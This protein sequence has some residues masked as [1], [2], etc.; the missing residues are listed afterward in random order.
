MKS[1]FNQLILAVL[2]LTLT[3]CNKE[4]H[5]NPAVNTDINYLE[6]D[7]SEITTQYNKEIQVFDESG[8][9]SVTYNIGSFE[10]SALEEYLNVVNLKIGMTYPGMEYSNSSES[11]DILGHDEN[12][13]LQDQVISYKVT[14][15]D[16]DRKANGFYL[17]VTYDQKSL[18]IGKMSSYS[19]QDDYDAPLYWYW[20]RVEHGHSNNSNNDVLVWWYYRNCSTCSM[21][22]D[23][24]ATLGPNQSSTYNRYNVRRIRA[25]VK[26]NWWNYR[27]YFKK[28][29][30]HTCDQ[31]F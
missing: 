23:R 27:V 21:N 20:G 29:V 15:L 1:K 4:D 6:F 7:R 14:K 12:E 28:Y 10:E 17:D 9:Y 18:A 5:E 13:N 22:Y 26:S 19:T 30:E 24:A 2:M 31:Y 3:A 25:H 8:R 16:L 11:K